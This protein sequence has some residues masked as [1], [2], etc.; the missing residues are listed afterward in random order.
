[1][2]DNKQ[3]V[4]LEGNLAEYPFFTYRR[5]IKREITNKV[6][7]M[8]EVVMSD[9]IRH[10]RE[11]TV[12]APLG[13][14]SAFDQDVLMA[15]LRI[16]TRDKTLTEK[17]YFTLYEIADMIGSKNHEKLVKQSIKRLLATT[18][19]A[20]NTVLIKGGESAKH[21]KSVS[22]KGFHIFEEFEYLCREEANKRLSRDFTYIKLNGFF[23]ENF[24][25]GYFKYIDFG[26]YLSLDTPLAK[27][28]YMYLEKKKFEKKM[29]EI[30]IDK[31]ALV[32][33]IEA[34]DRREVR[35]TLKENSD[36]L[37]EKR[38]IKSYKT[39]KDNIIYYFGKQAKEY[40][41][42]ISDKKVE[43]VD[44]LIDI[45]ITKAVAI[46]LI[47][48]YEQERIRK[49]VEYLKYRNAKN[50]AGVLIN[51]IKEDWAP[52]AEYAEEK[53][54]EEERQ[55]LLKEREEDAQKSKDMKENE[56][57]LNIL[58][59]ELTAEE[60]EIY[61]RR[62][63]EDFKRECPGVD[64]RYFNIPYRETLIKKYVSEEKGMCL[65]N[66]R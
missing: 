48:E 41:V 52:P 53:K 21:L 64:L 9:G 8:G 12:A 61:N 4:K 57:K 35:R 33:P 14:P 49:Q 29:Y 30:G 27:K 7:N 37:I 31:L 58:I 13:M 15:I 5:G 23:V 10:K 66:G 40:E 16:G 22:E 26:N 19:F 39:R 51:A 28:L 65:I 24:V 46:Q 50:R 45:G 59:S 63:E 18:Y 43:I 11:F 17:I 20:K 25:N 2:E 34:K 38:F 1:M 32:L 36:R 6:Y 60:L 42:L 54:K 55:K 56:Q 47:N 3:L 44:V 62:A